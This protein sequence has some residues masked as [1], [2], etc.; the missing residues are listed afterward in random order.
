MAKSKTDSDNAEKA[1]EEVK[2]MTEPVI[3]PIATD[4][5]TINK[6]FE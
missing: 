3:T 1:K 4:E 6:L 2:S 5:K